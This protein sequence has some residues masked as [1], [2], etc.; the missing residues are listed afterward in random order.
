MTNKQKLI[1]EMAEAIDAAI[2]LIERDYPE[3]DPTTGEYI[4]RQAREQFDLL[5]EVKATL[6]QTKGARE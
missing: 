3:S 1:A 5:C 2:K 6:T 4:D